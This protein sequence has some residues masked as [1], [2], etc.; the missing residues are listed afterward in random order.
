MKPGATQGAEVTVFSDQGTGAQGMAFEKANINGSG[1]SAYMFLVANAAGN[2][3]NFMSPFIPATDAWNHIYFV[4][5]GTNATIYLNGTSVTSRLYGGTAMATQAAASFFG[6]WRIHNRDWNGTI[7]DFSFRMG[8]AG[9]FAEAKADYDGLA[10][11]FGAIQSGVCW[12]IENKAL[13]IPKQC[14]YVLGIDWE[15]I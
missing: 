9:N 11:S 1:T 5:N 4:L 10:W 14:A 8:Y 6:D 3:W 12:W 13:V 15:E 2:D 7:D